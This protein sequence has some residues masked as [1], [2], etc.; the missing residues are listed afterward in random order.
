MEELQSE[1]SFQEKNTEI[2]LGSRGIGECKILYVDDRFGM[3]ENGS[4]FYIVLQNT[5]KIIYLKGC[6]DFSFLGASDRGNKKELH[7]YRKV[8]KSGMST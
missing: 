7:P 1:R 4:T 8:I 6:P 2:F 5:K 3:L